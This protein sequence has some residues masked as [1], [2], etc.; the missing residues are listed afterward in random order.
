LNSFQVTP[1]LR[2]RGGPLGIDRDALHLGEVDHHA[3]VSHGAAGD[4]VPAAPDRH[5]KLAAAGKRECCDDVLDAP[6]ADDQRRL[7][8]D[9][10]VVH[11]ACRV[12][13]RMIGREHRTGNTAPELIENMVVQRGAHVVLSVERTSVRRCA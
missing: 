8:V 1:A 10:A 6:G 7:A 3:A 5:L 13:P 4:V 9:E 2:A 12:V 11:G